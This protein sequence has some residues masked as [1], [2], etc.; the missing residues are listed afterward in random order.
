MNQRSTKAIRHA[1]RIKRT[2]GRVIGTAER[3]RLS[4]ARSHRNIEVQLVD[5]VSGKTLC[6][7]SSAARD[8]R[9]RVKYGGNV[10]AAKLI[11]QALGQKAKALG[12]EKVCFDRR[13]FRYHGRVKAVAEAAR[14]AGLKF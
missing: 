10:A 14:E 7:A 3:P 6:A 1:R 2:R 5:D 11:G 13:G 8:L 12:V 4:I 9:E